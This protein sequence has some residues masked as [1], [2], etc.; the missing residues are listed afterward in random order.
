MSNPTKAA[1]REKSAPAG[2][3]YRVTNTTHFINGSLMAPG[4]VVQ[5]PADVKPGKYLVEVDEA[6][7]DVKAK[8]EKA[9]K[10]DVKPGT[11]AK[12]DDPKPD[13]AKA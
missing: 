7:K 12:A 6:G 9:E 11:E 10:A 2:K 4:G 13:G 5:L 8:P 1:P 3:R